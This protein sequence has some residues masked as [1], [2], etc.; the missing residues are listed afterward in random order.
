MKQFAKIMREIAEENNNY[1][2]TENLG[3]QYRTSGSSLLDLFAVLGAM[4]FRPETELK[5]MFEKAFEEDK[6]L[7]LRMVFY[8][9]NIREGGLGER[10]V[11][12]ILLRWL[13]ENSLPNLLANIHLIPEMGRWDDLFSLV[14]T[15]A[16]EEAMSY[17]AEQ[18][19][20]DWEAYRENKPISL[21]AKWA[22]SANTTSRGSRGLAKILIHY[23]NKRFNP[24]KL[25]ER[26]YRKML[27]KLRSYSNVVETKMSSGSWDKIDYESVPSQ[28]MR[29][30]KNAFK[31]HDDERFGNFIE[32][33][34]SGKA[35]INASTLYPYDIVKEY[36]D[37]SFY[38][39]G[40]INWFMNHSGLNKVSEEQWRALPNYIEG[41]NNIVVMADTS[42]S[43]AG[44]PMAVSM[45]LAVYFA[46]R[47]KGA[48]KDL[49][50]TF[51]RRP[52]FVKLLGDSL[53]EKLSNIPIF[54]ENTNIDIAFDLILHTAIENNVPQEE[55][56]KAL[57]I[58]SDMEFDECDDS[59]S[60]SYERARRKFA[61]SGYELPKIVF[62]NVSQRTKGVQVKAGDVGALLVSGASAGTFKSV[63]SCLEKTP[64]E[65]M[66]SVLNSEPYKDIHAV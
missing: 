44:L 8:A 37:G 54:A 66:L 17:Y 41:E 34:G 58:I 29:V 64:Y 19:Y 23:Y 35:K 48:Y 6:T 3:K 22:K 52:R 59:E 57:L 62:W 12:R 14:A 30:Y 49:F 42:G 9:R 21:A 39:M 55:M 27:S 56:P 45:S 63:L 2:F 20:K 53:Y 4:R 10:R 36:I 15:P 24:Y 1:S 31:K 43:M 65:F 7:A 38:S 50:M 51:S 26:G 40:N 5:A 25:T 13:A 46:E 33:V 47:N 18:L 28:A 16:E 32:A 61:E 60:V 11:F